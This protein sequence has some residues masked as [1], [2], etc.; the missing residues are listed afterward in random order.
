[1][2]IVVLWIFVFIK[3]IHNVPNSTGKKRFNPGSATWVVKRRGE[4][5]T[6]LSTWTCRSFADISKCELNMLHAQTCPHHQ[7]QA[8]LLKA[9]HF[10]HKE[11]GN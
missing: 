2:I 11:M 6:Q 4:I 7:V 1:M 9:L 5:H 3:H 8:Q 10:M